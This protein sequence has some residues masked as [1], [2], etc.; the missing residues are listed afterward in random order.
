M[1]SLDDASHTPETT[2]SKGSSEYFPSQLF[3]YRLPYFNKWHHLFI[4]APILFS[5]SNLLSKWE[6]TC[7][8]HKSK[9]FLHCWYPSRVSH[10]NFNKLKHL[11]MSL[12][13]LTPCMS[14]HTNHTYTHTTHTCIYHIH[15]SH[16]D[17]PTN[18][19]ILPIHP[20]PI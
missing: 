7:T 15:T 17:V 2:H 3:P 19:W 6:Y 18:G 13:I 1:Q 14:S 4:G 16:K 12:H 5:P 20:I 8:K 11:H 10:Y 9:Y